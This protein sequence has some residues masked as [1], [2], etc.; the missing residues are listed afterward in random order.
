MSEAMQ[1]QFSL[2]RRAPRRCMHPATAVDVVVDSVTGDV[3]G[4]GYAAARCWRFR[5]QLHG[6]SSVI[7]LSGS[8]RDPDDAWCLVPP[9][10]TAHQRRA[11]SA[12]RLCRARRT[13]FEPRD[14]KHERA[15]AAIARTSRFVSYR[16]GELTC[17]VYRHLREGVQYGARSAA[18]SSPA[19]TGLTGG[20]TNKAISAPFYY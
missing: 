15:T 6:R 7:R 10:P 18:L 8:R 4:S 14:L 16:G 11:L 20:V 9:H 1:A 12:E 17:N 3:I 5:F 2:L 13:K 19:L